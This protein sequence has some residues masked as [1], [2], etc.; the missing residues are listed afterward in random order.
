MSE[1]FDRSQVLGFFIDESQEQ[2]GLLNNLILSLEKN[3]GSMD[4]INEIFRTAHTLKG[5]SGMMGFKKVSDLAHAMEDLLGV[6]RDRKVG[7]TPRVMDVLFRALDGI[8]AFLSGI[9]ET[10]IEPDGETID[11]F[12]DLPGL[13]RDI[14]DRMEKKGQDFE[15][16]TEQASPEAPG[17]GDKSK[18]SVPGKPEVI[19][20]DPEEEIFKT[21]DWSLKELSS[22]PTSRFG[23]SDIQRSAGRACHQEH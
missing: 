22:D 13:L 23:L 16:Q 4:L 9:S 11:D 15:D 3:P 5:A 19:D 6:M 1:S 2:I 7:V 17:S 14:A 21:I 12:A 8:G 20:V 18:A 10:G